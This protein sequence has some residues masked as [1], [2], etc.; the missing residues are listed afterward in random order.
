MT[1]YSLDGLLFLFGTSLFVVPCPVLTV[2][3]WP[4]HRF[5]KRQVRWS[6]IP[7]SYR[8]FHSL[9]WFTQSKALAYAWNAGDQGSIPGL[10]RYPGEGNGN[11]HQYSCLGNPVIRGCCWAAVHGV[12]KCWAQR[13]KLNNNNNTATIVWSHGMFDKCCCWLKE[14]NNKKLEMAT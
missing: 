13:K 1:I 8:I 10:G 6:G 4:A 11:P 12:T 2:A 3:S 14:R 7:I 5:L 9:L